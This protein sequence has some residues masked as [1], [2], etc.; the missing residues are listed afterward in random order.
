[1][2]LPTRDTGTRASE[3]TFVVYGLARDPRIVLAD[4]ERAGAGVPPLTGRYAILPD[5]GDDVRINTPG[6]IDI[7]VDER[8]ELAKPDDL[9]LLCREAICHGV[10]S[11]GGPLR[12]FLQS[13]LNFVDRRIAEAAGELEALA[14][15]PDVFTGRDWVFSAY[16]P[17]PQ[18][19]VLTPEP[20]EDGGPSFAEFDA[21]LWCQ[22]CLLCVI[23]EGVGMVRKSVQRNRDILTGGQSN[24]NIIRVPKDAFSDDAFPEEM[25]PVRIGRFWTGLDMPFGP[26]PPLI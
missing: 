3:R 23:I 21:V 11:F 24:I 25:F 15:G 10:S 8:L 26:C 14:H 19:R 6:W 18:A 17:M 12:R 7:T 2:G 20:A 1:M 4:V 5:A 9:Q 22:G 13:Y 16:L